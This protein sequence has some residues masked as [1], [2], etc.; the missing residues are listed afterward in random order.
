MMEM[1]ESLKA[2]FP[3]AATI[4][5][6]L[7]G[8]GFLT[9]WLRSGEAPAPVVEQSTDIE[10]VGVV[11]EYDNSRCPCGMPATHPAPKLVR[12][13]SGN[14]QAI[15]AMAPRYKRVVPRA[16]VLDMWNGVN[17]EAVLCES[18]AHMADAEMDNFIYTVIRAKQ[19]ELNGQLAVQAASFETEALLQRIRDNL[20]DEQKKK[21][22][23]MSVRRNQ[24]RAVNGPVSDGFEN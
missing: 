17:P 15:Y 23:Q 6:V 16:G 20:T 3:Y 12:E 9:R 1:Y 4:T 19:A 2:V 10:L 13:R 24:L 21:V 18:H 5:V 11:Q 22:R 14:T 8:V 7:L